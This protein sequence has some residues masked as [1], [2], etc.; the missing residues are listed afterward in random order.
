MTHPSKIM[1]Y[2]WFFETTGSE[3]RPCSAGYGEHNA[4]LCDQNDEWCIDGE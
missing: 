1:H 3:I 2:W 4:V